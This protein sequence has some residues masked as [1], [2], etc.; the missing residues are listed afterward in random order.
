MK[1]IICSIIILS[2]VV[3]ISYLI[4][5]SNKNNDVS[6]ENNTLNY[7]FVNRYNLGNYDNNIQY[8]D[9]LLTNYSDYLSFV[10]DYKLDKEL[11]EN[12]FKSNDYI[13]SFID[14][15]S[16]AETKEKEVNKV[17]YTEED[18]NLTVEY[19]VYNDCGVCPVEIIVYLIKID[20]I[21]KE[22]INIKNSYLN[23]NEDNCDPNVEYKPILYLYPEKDIYVNVKLEKSNNIITSYPKYNNGWNVQV[24]KDGTLI[25]N[26][27]K[28]YALYW[29]EYNDNQVDFHEGF[30]VTKENAIEFLEEKLDIIGLNYKEANEFIMYW[31]PILEKNEQS[32][33]YFELTDERENNNRLIIDPKPDSLL[34]I[35]IH[36]KKVDNYVTIKEQQLPSFERVGFVAV[37]WGG[38]IHE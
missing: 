10:N 16:C 14:Y 27:K 17:I 23:M 2:I 8:Q 38:T 26:E 12:D 37:E 30:Y 31:L 35:N 32:I 1:K 21:N 11:N 33:V 20:K 9:T 4:L 15:D 6:I 28:Y 18:N 19:N 34:R 13:V 7:Q 22:N 36:I 5:N 29:D 25:I 3:L 24:K